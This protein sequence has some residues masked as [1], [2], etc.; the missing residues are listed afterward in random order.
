[1]PIYTYR[2]LKCRAP[3]TALLRVSERDSKAPTCERC[4]LT[5]LREPS[6]SNFQLK[7]TGWYKPSPVED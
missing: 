2:C 1:M 4:A 3:T 7:G 6:V 5:M